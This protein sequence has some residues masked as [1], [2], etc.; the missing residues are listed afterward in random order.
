[1][2]LP[3]EEFSL[4]FSIYLPSI[5][6]LCLRSARG[7]PPESNVQLLGRSDPWRAAAVKCQRKKNIGKNTS[8]HHFI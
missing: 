5:H 3:L 7:E 1:M 8:S 6:L 4:S 2:Y